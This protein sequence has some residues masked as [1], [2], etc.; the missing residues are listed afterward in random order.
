MSELILT[1]L[2]G[3]NPLAFLAALGTLR[4]LTRAWPESNVR[5]SWTTDGGWRP[6]INSECCE[7][8]SIVEALY[9][10]LQAAKDNATLGLADNLTIPADEYRA[11]LVQQIETQEDPDSDATAYC[12]AFG[13]D[14]IFDE[15]SGNIK[16]TA[17]R[18]MSG[19]G[20]QHF[21]KTMRDVL[22]QTT[23]EHI[24][25]TLFNHWQYDDPLA[26]LSLRFD[27]SDDK[28]YALR[29]DDPS[30]DPTR[31][32]QGNMLGANAL[33]VLGIPFLVVAPVCGGLGSTGFKGSL[34]RD[35][36]WTWPM[37]KHPASL[38]VARSLLT[39]SELQEESPPRDRLRPRGI[40]EVFRSQR[41]TTG[42][43]RNFTPAQP[44]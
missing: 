8:E 23:K 21:L 5:M 13:C 19:A 32:S 43:F 2:D 14:A 15:K 34:A 36:Y 10:R 12:A 22:A 40:A 44:V 42:K 18:T 17:L 7:P 24:D 4:G 25:K 3:S 35:T 9:E 11:H 29:W 38:D 26:T 30:G 41:L 27:P 1:G 33:A 28:R 16:D 39:L 6:V 31:R 20:H 37:W